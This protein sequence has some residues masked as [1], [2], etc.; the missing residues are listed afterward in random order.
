LL[1]IEYYSFP[2]TLTIKRYLVDPGFIDL[3]KVFFTAIGEGVTVNPNTSSDDE[4]GGDLSTDDT[5]NDRKSSV[6][7]VETDDDT[8]DD[9][10]DDDADDDD[11]DD[12]EMDDEL[13]VDSPSTNDNEDTD[14]KEK[15]NTSEK[16]DD[17]YDDGERSRHLQSGRDTVIDLIFFHEPSDCTKTADGCDWTLLGVGRKNQYGEV[18]YCCT[19]ESTSSGVCE[20]KNIGR[21]IID[22][23]LFGGE[24]RPLLVPSSGEFSSGVNIPVMPTKQGTGKYTLAIA[25]CN[26]FGRDMYINGKYIWKSK[27]GYLPG[28]LFDEWHFLIIFLIGYSALLFWYGKSMWNN[29]DATIDIQKWIVGTLALGLLELLLKT[30]DYFEWN[31]YG[32]R[33]EIIMYS[34]IIVGVLKGAISRCVLVMV[35]LGW[36]V[37]RDTLGDQL[38][39]I[40]I[41]GIVFSISSFARD[42]AE[43]VFVE[44]MQTWSLEKEEEVYDVFSILTFVVAAIDCIFYMWILDALNSTMQYLENMNQSNKLKRYLRLR[45]ILLISILFGIVWAVF[46]IVDASMETA[47][48]DDG[49]EWIIRGMW[50]VNYSFVLVAIALLWKPDPRS[51]EFAYVMELPSVGDDTVLQQSTSIQDTDED[52]MNIRYSDN[53][54]GKFTIDD[55]EM[56]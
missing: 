45:L 25:N 56:S 12:D 11:T 35:S 31:I 14:D 6:P 24:H 21:L 47:I 22:P 44:E 19:E 38:I 13:I 54:H 43:V 37:V 1:V 48:L 23:E 17:Y 9:D 7:P 20:N 53:N 39:K 30:M 50:V 8:D 49:Q 40:I 55:G 15:I 42:V 41:L 33:S 28:N 34:W 16:G 27:G 32:V 52:E 10:T 4:S 3:T 29:K 46:G 36:G 18:E 2:F 26:D 5:D 51:K